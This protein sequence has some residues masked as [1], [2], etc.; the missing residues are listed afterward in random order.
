MC[1][2][3]TGRCT[4]TPRW[5]GDI[6][7]GV[8]NGWKYSTPTAWFRTLLKYSSSGFLRSQEWRERYLGIYCD[9]YYSWSKVRWYEVPHFG[10][11][12]LRWGGDVWM[13]VLKDWKYSTPTDWLW[14]LLKKQL[15]W[16]PAFAGMT[17]RYLGIYYDE[18]YSGTKVRLYEMPPY[19]T[20]TLRWGGD[21][22]MGVLKG[23]KYST[24]T[25]W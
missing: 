9:E 24:P 17:E 11:G 10:T 19:G 18:Y 13:G 23:W 15:L 22:W 2:W 7:M 6:W 16:I 4:S 3:F 5:G 14:T 8:L 1:C 20:G 25:G 21:V 12:T